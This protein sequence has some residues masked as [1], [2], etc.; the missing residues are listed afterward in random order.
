MA[1]VPWAPP[2]S[3]ALYALI[4]LKLCSGM[5]V[6]A[7]HVP[8]IA[9]GFFDEEQKQVTHPASS[10][11][12]VAAEQSAA[13]AEG[14]TAADILPTDQATMAQQVMDQLAK[15]LAAQP[16]RWDNVFARFWAGP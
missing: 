2:D 4:N 15:F 3:L 5:P 16:V 7:S 10:E 14:A 8:F 1:D 13:I 12:D 9:Y 11:V 6:M